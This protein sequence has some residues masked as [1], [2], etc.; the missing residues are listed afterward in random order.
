MYCDR[1]ALLIKSYKSHCKTFE[2]KCELAVA[3][4]AFWA[5]SLFNHQSP[6]PYLLS[7][8]SSD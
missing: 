8:N 3:F 5:I 4:F 1:S 6:T 2:N 7:K